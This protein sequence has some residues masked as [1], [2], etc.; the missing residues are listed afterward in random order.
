MKD[1]GKGIG[2]GM[3]GLAIGFACWATK[4][5]APCWGFLFLAWM[6]GAWN[7]GNCNCKKDEDE[8]DG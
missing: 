4:S 3:C 6:A 8:N 5:A 2:I 1:L 7:D